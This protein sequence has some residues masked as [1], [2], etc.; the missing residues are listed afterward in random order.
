MGEKMSL[1]FGVVPARDEN[2]KYLDPPEVCQ[3]KQIQA[4][5]DSLKSVL[6]GS[7]GVTFHPIKKAVPC[8]FCNGSDMEM[9]K[10]GF[11]PLCQETISRLDYEGWVEVRHLGRGK[12]YTLCTSCTLIARIVVALT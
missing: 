10:E 4:L 1:P 11:N 9:R 7:F 12:I 3:R 2:G 6:A 5:R 8:D